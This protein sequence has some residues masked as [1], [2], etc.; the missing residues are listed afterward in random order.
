MSNSVFRGLKRLLIRILIVQFLLGFLPQGFAHLDGI[1]NSTAATSIK[2]STNVSSDTLR[3]EQLARQYC[4]SCHLFPEPDLLDKATWE[5]GALPWMSKWLGI[6][7][8]NLALR[9]G[10]RFVEAAGLFPPSPILPVPD[11]EAIC[12]YYIESAPEKPLPQ[13]ARPKIRMELKRFEVV[14]PDYRFQIPLTTL[15]KI[16]PDSKQFYLG[17]AGTKTLNVLD[18]RGNMK[19]S[20]PV[21]SPPVSLVFKQHHFYATL[22][23]SVTPS[24]EPQGE[25]VEFK[26]STNGFQ[27]SLVL[28]E[29][30]MR[31]VEAVFADLNNDGKE[32]FVVCGFG[33]YIGRFSWFESLGDNKYREHTLFDRP[34]AVRACVYDFNKDGLPDIIVM[35]AQAREGIYIFTNKGNGEFNMSPVVEFHPAFGSSYFE[36][37]DFNQDGFIDILA[38]NGD[39][40]EYASSLKNYHGIRLYLND[41]KNNFREAWFFPLNGAYK[42]MAADFNKD[43]NMDIAA[44]SY[45]PDYENGAEESFVYLENRGQL[46]F[47]AYSFPESRDGRWLT[48]NV[49]DLDGDGCPDIVLGSFIRGP[50]MVP[51][52]FS[53]YWEKSG[54]SFLILKNNCSRK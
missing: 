15:V 33:N 24:D 44:I 49:G 9:P 36:L 23:G 39:N 53:E 46:Q 3:G 27:K 52:T 6:S 18:R 34:G 30:L 26:Q 20:C 50:N 41:G 31:P 19:F 37:V 43:G 32:D 8:M 17:D 5:K 42:A 14:S 29:N 4:Q 7:K 38:T 40:G 22:I 13:A 16:D 35:M 47:D 25:V 2:H 28:A 21:D 48:M 1:T 45:F 51:P 12:K 11:W 10:R 54:P